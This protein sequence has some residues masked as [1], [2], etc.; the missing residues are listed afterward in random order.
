MVKTLQSYPQKELEQFSHLRDKTEQLRVAK[1][2]HRLAVNPY[3]TVRESILGAFV[4]MYEPHLLP[5]MRML[6]KKGYVVEKSSGFCGEGFNCQTLDGSFSIDFITINKLAKIGVKIHSRIQSKSMRFWPEIAD[7][8]TIQKKYLQI[9]DVLP[10]RNGP[11]EPSLTSDAVEFRRTYVPSNATLK[12]KRLFEILQFNL[13]N[14]ILSD[15][16]KRLKTNPIP[17][18]AEMALGMF[19]EMVEPQLREAILILYKKGY[20]TDVS[21]FIEKNDYQFIEGDF[22]L[23]PSV[24]DKLIFI[25]VIVETNRSGYTRL[26][27][28]PDSPNLENIR[29]K[30]IKIASFFPKKGK[31]AQQSMTLRAREFRIKYRPS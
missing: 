7:L 5:I 17:T 14:K 28:L 18:Q 6:L 10:Q 22:T 27:F 31:R 15:V 1:I 26:Q 20:S 16:K 12:K 13:Q 3:P 4:E 8:R 19:M 24:A 30:W 11:P 23:E 9:A 29:D 21:G 25:G 2:Q